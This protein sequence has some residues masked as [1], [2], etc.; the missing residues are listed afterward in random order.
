MIMQKNH[1]TVNILGSTFT[2]V[3]DNDEEY[4]GEVVEYLIMKIEEV[5]QGFA[6]IDP[7]K[8][9]LLTSLNLVDELFKVK[10]LIY[11]EE[12]NDSL[13]IEQLTERLINKID[14]SLLEN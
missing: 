3:S 11:P 10:K 6:K 8:I 2:I 1:L 7:L 5:K 14:E 13:E 12:S 4:L 9:S